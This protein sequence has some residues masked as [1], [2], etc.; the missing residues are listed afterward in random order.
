MS[1][2]DP[3]KEPED[4]SQGWKIEE[5]IFRQAHPRAV[6]AR[7]NNPAGLH[8]LLALPSLNTHARSGKLENL[9]VHHFARISSKKY[10]ALD[11]CV[12]ITLFFE[13]HF[14]LRFETLKQFWSRPY[15][16][17]LKLYESSIDP[18]FGICLTSPCVA[19][20]DQT[21]WRMQHKGKD[22]KKVN[23][24]SGEILGFEENALLTELRPRRW[25]SMVVLH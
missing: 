23:W 2:S 1:D 14:F 3:W 15:E 22:R 12:Y 5:E 13:A 10:H 18:M 24:S 19:N 8:Y 20:F 25:R 7:S 6:L 9:T 11:M 16:V 21:N 4:I 17:S